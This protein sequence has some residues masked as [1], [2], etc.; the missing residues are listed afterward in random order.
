MLLRRV[1]AHLRKQEWTAVAIDFVIVVIGVFIGLQVNNWNAA[2]LDRAREALILDRLQS[3]FSRLRAATL[4]NI[5]DVSRDYEGLDAVVRSLAHRAVAP[6]DSD[7]FRDGLRWGYHYQQLAGRSGTYVELTSSG[8]VDLIN[9]EALRAALVD[10][11]QIVSDSATGFL[12]IRSLQTA[13]AP[14]FTRHYTLSAEAKVDVGESSTVDA[15]FYSA[16]ADVD[17]YDFANMLADPSFR[18]SAEE[19]RQMQAYYLGW[20]R[21]QFDLVES[22]CERLAVSASRPCTTPQAETTAR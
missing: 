15:S 7:R 1:V 16:L 21:T 3:D 9:D 13:M 19:L 17:A 18:D 14:A 6:A 11:D 20:H 12:H 22:V 8:Q 4:V 5:D 10:Y 2:R